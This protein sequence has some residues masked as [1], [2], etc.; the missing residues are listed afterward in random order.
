MVLDHVVVV[1]VIAHI[2]SAEAAKHCHTAAVHAL[3]VDLCF[4]VFVTNL[5]ARTNFLQ[6]ALLA[7]EILHFGLLLLSIVHL[8][9]AVYE[10]TKVRLLA[11]EALVEGAPMVGVLL[12]LAVVNVVFVGKSL[13]GKDTLVLSVDQGLLLN[14]FLETNQ[15]SKLLRDRL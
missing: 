8:L 7:A 9:F 11:V 3:P 12:G 4:A 13:I 14:D 1:T 10:A 15:W 5:L 6:D 2:V